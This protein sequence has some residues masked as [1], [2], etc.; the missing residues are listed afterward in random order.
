MWTLISW[1]DISQP[2]HEGRKEMCFTGRRRRKWNATWRM[3]RDGTWNKTIRASYKVRRHRHPDESGG[4][5][6]RVCAFKWSFF[7]KCKY[8]ISQNNHCTHWCTS[9]FCRLW[10]GGIKCVICTLENVH[11]HSHPQG[12]KWL[13]CRQGRYTLSRIAVALKKK[14]FKPQFSSA[15]LG[16]AEALMKRLASI[17]IQHTKTI[18]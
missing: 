3:W 17:K 7:W 11:I 14:L 1:W 16:P 10:S 9:G 13:R 18:L 2:C 8:R 12:I 4:C 5:M 6:K 15:T